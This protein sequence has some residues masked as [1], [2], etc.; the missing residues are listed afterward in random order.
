MQTTSPE[1]AVDPRVHLKRDVSPPGIQ[2]ILPPVPAFV[3]V[4]CLTLSVFGCGKPRRRTTPVRFG[5]LSSLPGTAPLPLQLTRNELEASIVA[6]LMKRVAGRPDS[7][8]AAARVET[9]VVPILDRVLALPANMR[10]LR[11]IAASR[12]EPFSAARARWEGLLAADIYIESGGLPDAISPAG[13]VGVSQWMPSSGRGMGLHVDAA[14]STDLTAQISA[15]QS[16]GTGGTAP[17]SPAAL[18][19][20]RIAMLTA[21]RAKADERYN[22][23]LAIAA[24][25]GYLL[26][27]WQHLPAADWLMQAYHGGAGGVKRLIDLFLGASTSTAASIARGAGGSR[28]SYPMIYFGCSPTSHVR[29]FTYLYSR[30]DDHRYYWWK[31]LAAM[32]LLA[33][34]RKSPAAAAAEWSQLAP[35]RLMEAAWYPAGMQQAIPDMP[36]LLR[37]RAQGVLVPVASSAALAAE[38]APLDPIHA[39]PYACVRPETLGAL[40][41]LAAIYRRAGGQAR[42]QLG[43]LT[44]T[45]AYQRLQV[46]KWPD[47]L[48]AQPAPEMPD[49]SATVGPPPAFNYHTTG[50]AAD[51]LQPKSR[52]E[53]LRLLWALGALSDRGIIA[54]VRSSSGGPARYHLV[55]NPAYRLALQKV[56]STGKLPRL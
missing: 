23:D 50:I 4:A 5:P 24:Q 32:Q 11:A 52:L 42:L 31:L 33:V 55:P 37:A 48:Q 28:L 41:L 19:A 6:S 1:Q 51:V 53:Q 26:S 29:A 49:G 30:S 13:A 39:E 38:P 17:G 21:E 25:T 27:E 35:G 10:A 9:N 14:A 34:Y 43:D 16:Q 7:L 3:V 36:T 40:K 47:S 12:H 8:D 20:S 22:P 18:A 54:W 46:A 44:I 45:V 15:L 2:R 56:A